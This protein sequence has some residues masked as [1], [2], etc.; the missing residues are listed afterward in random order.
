V[1]TLNF[2]TTD[3]KVFTPV[4]SALGAL[5]NGVGTIIALIHMTTTGGADMVGL[6]DAGPS[7]YYHDLQW[8]GDSKLHDDDNH[9]PGLGSTATFTQDT[10]NWWWIALDWPSTAAAYR[11]HWRNHTAGGS[12]THDPSNVSGAAA[13]AG[14]GTGWV[15]IGAAGDNSA[16]ARD[17]ALAAIWA[18]TRFVDADYGIWTKTSDLYN[19]AK[20][21]PTFL[22]ELN[23]TTLVD[24]IAGS[25]YSSGNSSGTGLTGGNPPT[26]TFDGLGAPI[27]ND[28]KGGLVPAGML[29]PEL[30]SQAWF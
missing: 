3:R 9:T 30:N 18:G 6:T 29:D 4:S 27:S 2:A 17:M 7:N 22:C 5:S 16:G 23:A 1:A 10:T 13:F 28:A 14:P 11:F 24:L 25:T 19:H 8:G 20:G 12:W 15:R 26:W 21:P